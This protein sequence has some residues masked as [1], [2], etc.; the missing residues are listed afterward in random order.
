MVGTFDD[1]LAQLPFATKLN[2]LLDMVDDL[3]KGKDETLCALRGEA[4]KLG[5]P[6]IIVGGV[7]VICHGYER[8]TKDRDVLVS[9]RHAKNLGNHLW[10]HADWERL[11]ISEYAFVYRPTG[12][13]VDFLV[14]KD[15]MT[16]G[17]P[18]YF[19][20]P[21]EV[22]QAQKHV[23]QIPVIGLHDLLYFKLL[24]GRMQD[25]SDIM[26]LVKLHLEE[27][28][29]DRVLSKLDSL[30]E[31]R[32]NKWLEILANAPKEIANERRLGQ[33]ITYTKEPQRYRPK[34]NRNE[35]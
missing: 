21:S 28:E 19:P 26:Q 34:R 18:Y 33:G 20:E 4:E 7:A 24:A 3:A 35:P 32:K 23:E 27:I 11:E 16:L 22:E 8:T 1:Y 13:K 17:Q 30:D 31:E 10:D 14:G 5:V 25:L 29:P 9:H 2:L 15:L 6:L 12:I